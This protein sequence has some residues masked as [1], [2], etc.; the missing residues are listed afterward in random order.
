MA[1]VACACPTSL[2]F[3]QRS[4]GWVS[5]G[6][7]MAQ[8]LL[9][10]LGTVAVG[11]IVASVVQSFALM[12]ITHHQHDAERLERASVRAH[13]LELRRAEDERRLRDARLDRLRRDARELTRALFDLE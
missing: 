7:T 10:I 4:S 8:V 11:A 9:I 1:T 3:R 2:R 6:G 13:E 5:I 12:W